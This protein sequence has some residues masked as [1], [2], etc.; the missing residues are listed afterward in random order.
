MKKQVLFL[1]MWIALPA[2]VHAQSVNW[3]TYRQELS[4]GLGASNFLGEL[5]GANQ[6]GSD[7][8]RDLEFSLTRPTVAIGYRY[9]ISPYFAAKANLI[10]GRV[11]GDDELTEE[12][13]RKNRNLHF[14][15][16]IVELSAQFEFYPFQEKSGH[17][18]RFKGVRGQRA[19]HLSPYLFAGIGGFWFNP[20]A[21]A[22]D[23]NWYALQPLGTEG[24]NV[25][26][27]GRS[28]YKQI[29]VALPVGVGLKYSLTKQLSFGLELGMRYTMTDYIDDV[30][31]DYWD[32][33]EIQAVSGPIAAELADPSTGVVEGAIIQGEKRG[34]PD[35]NDAYMFA[36]FSINYKLIRGKLHLP[37][38]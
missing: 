28:P 21:Q 9:H 22:A 23:G 18:Y 37:K 10:Y 25:P 11:N 20:H 16:P 2:M 15:S 31:L 32:T 14:R 3:K 1:L 4:F 27:S 33:D 8:L 19:T 36:I 5:G 26:G 35:R 6:V 34:N 17:L 24:Q 30:S 13:F 38:F 12:I 7:G 29:S